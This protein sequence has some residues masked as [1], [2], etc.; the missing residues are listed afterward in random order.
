MLNLSV[1]K[2]NFLDSCFVVFIRYPLGLI[3]KC[4]QGTGKEESVARII[5]CDRKTTNNTWIHSVDLLDLL[6]PLFTFRFTLS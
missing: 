5:G 3:L 1:G 4:I 2:N 6:S